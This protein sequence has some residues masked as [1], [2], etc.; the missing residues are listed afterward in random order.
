[1]GESRQKEFYLPEPHND[2]IFSIIGDELGLIG[3]VLLIGVYIIIMLRGFRIASRAPDYY[4]FV[5]AS[6]ITLTILIYS[7]FNMCITLGLVPPTGLPLPLVS[8]GGTSLIMSMYSIG[9]LLN[10]SYK[11]KHPDVSSDQS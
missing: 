9:V 4:G 10:I 2:F 7:L 1:L 5:L 8:Y 11:S 3:T 6:G